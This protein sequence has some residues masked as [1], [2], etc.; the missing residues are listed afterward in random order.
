MPL[1]SARL[2]ILELSVPGQERVPAGVLLEDRARDRLYVRLRRDWDEIAPDE[3]EVLS[4]LSQ[5]LESKATEMGATALLGYLEDTLSNVLSF[6]SQSQLEVDEFERTLSRAYRENV[7]SIVR[8]FVTH[9]PRYSLAVAAGKFLEN[10]EVEEEDWEE[11]PPAL[12]LSP[13]MFAA[14]I[15]GRSME[16]LIPDGSLCAVW[17]W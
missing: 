12:R 8:P 2:S 4:A 10:Q 17:C 3:A 5:D 15:R 1:N 11:T 7:R 14:R 16:P 6:S 9:I 13:G